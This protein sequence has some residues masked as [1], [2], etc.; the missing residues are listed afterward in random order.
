MYMEALKWACYLT[1]LLASI[2]SMYDQCNMDDKRDHSQLE[3]FWH[4][5]SLKLSH[6]IH[7]LHK[8]FGNITNNPL[9]K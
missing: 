7:I 4:I 3:Y 1:Q 2:T 8:Q 5:I 9:I 6:V